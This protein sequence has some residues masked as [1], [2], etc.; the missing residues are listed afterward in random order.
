MKN[1]I[2]PFAL[3]LAVTI[4]FYGCA[5]DPNEKANKLY[6]E[7]SMEA[8]HFLNSTKVWDDSYSTLWNSYTSV[9]ERIDLILSKYPSSDIAVGLLSDK[10]KI[11]GLTLRQFQKKKDIVKQ[12]RDAEQSP[13]LGALLIAKTIENK[14][15]K[16]LLLIEIAQY[17]IKVGQ[18]EKAEKLLSQVLELAKTI[19]PITAKRRIL[20]DTANSYAAAGQFKIAIKTANTIE[21]AKDKTG[22]LTEIAEKYT[23]VGQ[24]E[25]ATQM[26]SQALDLAEYTSRKTVMLMNFLDKHI[27]L[28]EIG[29]VFEF[30]EKIGSEHA[31]VEVFSKIALNYAKAGQK[32]KAVYWFTQAVEII[33]TIDDPAGQTEAFIEIATVYYFFELKES[34]SPLF[35]LAFEASMKIEM[36]KKPLFLAYS[37]FMYDIFGN[38]LLNKDTVILHDII[39]TT[40]PMSQLWAKVINSPK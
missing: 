15:D 28:I 17:S 7:A 10:N 35:A 40:N 38:R 21:D 32:E 29:Q 6:V 8:S 34:L 31:K 39:T 12:L 1:R 13:F 25:Q 23:E 9:K 33:K 36:V 20:R 11:S 3:L 22:V 30:T 18:K 24:K 19:Y 27:G 2:F 26:L 37:A 4:F 16:A 14:F 5:G